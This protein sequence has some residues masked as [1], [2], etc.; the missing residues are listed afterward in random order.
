MPTP[1]SS[2]TPAGWSSRDG[3]TSSSP[4]AGST[5][6][7]G[8]CNSWRTSLLERDDEVIGKAYDGRLMRRPW[9]FTRPHGR[10]VLVSLLLFPPVAL[11]ELL[12]P[13]LVKIAIDEHILRADW[14]GLGRVS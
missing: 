8:A 7:S 13:Y 6:G 4:S 5:P 11:L 12:Q 10:L 14:T 3:T 2:W 9:A 1:S